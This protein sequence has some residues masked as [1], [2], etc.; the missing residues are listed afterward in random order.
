MPKIG[1]DLSVRA[2]G[3]TTSVGSTDHQCHVGVREIVVDVF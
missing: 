2:A 1:E 3:F